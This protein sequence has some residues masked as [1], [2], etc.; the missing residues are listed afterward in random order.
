MGAS[1]LLSGIALSAVNGLMIGIIYEAAFLGGFSSGMIGA[2]LGAFIGMFLG[3]PFALA[4]HEAIHT[5]PERICIIYIGTA[6]ALM[7]GFFLHPLL[8][9]AA[10]V[11][12]YASTSFLVAVWC[13]NTAVRLAAHLCANCQYD[14]TGIPKRICP[15]CGTDNTLSSV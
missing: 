1:S 8:V 5:K 14:M 10:L 13:T 15:E 9:V 4:C 12:A 7:L 3:F 2:I 6:A 11:T